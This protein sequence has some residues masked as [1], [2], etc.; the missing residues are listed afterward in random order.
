MMGRLPTVAVV[1]PDFG[2]TGGF[3][4]HVQAL[5]EGLRARGWPVTMIALDAT[6][7]PE[8]LYGLPVEPLWFEFSN[9][10]FQ[11]L[12]LVEQAQRLNLDHFDVVLTTQPPTFLVPHRHKVALF[13]HQARPMYDLAEPIMASG[14]VDTEVHALATRAVRELE[15]DAVQD[16]AHWLA[17]S[18]ESAA[19]LDYHWSIPTD[20]IEVYQA[21]P[22]STPASV[23]PYQ[24]DGPVVTVGRIEWPKRA[25]LVVQAMHL[26][27]SDRVAHL[28]G[29]GTRLELVRDLDVAWGRNRDEV[30]R[31][32]DPG[33]W[34]ET[35]V[36]PAHHGQAEGPPSGRVVFEGAVSDER[37][38]Q[39]YDQASVVVAPAYREDYGL[40]VIEAMLRARPVIVCRDGGGLTEMITN[41]LNGMIVEPNAMSLA[42]AIDGLVADPARAAR[43]G[44]AGRRAVAG[45][46]L[47]R[48]LDQVEG[49]LHRVLGQDAPT[50]NVDLTLNS[51]T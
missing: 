21:P 47:D 13:F 19:R 24:P 48:A 16:V 31:S 20:R 37:R 22:I 2:V 4:R 51:D 12:N 32:L 23:A 3:E 35:G 29:G 15:R 5:V 8:R 43:M 34:V 39:L 7:N 46:T 40:T 17:G 10:Y 11:Y 33:L 41:G 6:T 50:I 1:K 44:Q 28:V 26:S 42:K 18:A 38:D 45:I 30:S 49:A 9:D 36:V 14:L 27:A 25:E